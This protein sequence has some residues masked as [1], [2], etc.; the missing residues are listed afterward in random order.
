MS[1]K[2]A[3]VWSGV[4]S[5]LR[6]GLSFL[7]IKV[8]AFYLGPAGLALVGQLGNFITLL[9]GGLGN[10]IQTGVIKLTAEHEG[11]PEQQRAVWSSAFTLSTWLALGFGLLVCILAMP[12]SAWL[13][14]DTAYWP[15]FVLIG[16][17]TPFLLWNLVLTGA[18]NGIKQINALG[19]IS[20]AATVAGAV[21]FIPLSYVFGI[22]GGLAG[23]AIS[24]GAAFV[25]VL[26]AL[27]WIR[28]IR[29]RHFLAGH[30]PD[31]IKKLMSFYPMLI[32]HSVAV[33][34][35]TLLVR[36]MISSHLGLQQAGFWQAAWRLSDMYTQVLMLA[37]SMF[38]M[39]HLSGIKEE[40]VFGHELRSIVFKVTALTA[41]AALALYLLRD[42]LIL[43]VFTHEFK[44][45]S[46]LLLFQLLGDI[47]KM[48]GWPIR[49]ALVI[50][51][52]ARWYMFIEV[53]IALLQVTLTQFLLA[54]YGVKG[55]TMAYAASWLA[56]LI[57]LFIVTR[58]YWHVRRAT[59]D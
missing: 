30:Q 12:L 31:I 4:Q 34:L 5:V 23:T 52:R 47:F 53:A 33:P 54:G 17:L 43:I 44:P 18:V 51:L 40:R 19:A 20:V 49:M 6:L 56:A 21:I 15:A 36:D 57:V 55:A 3:L 16:G 50:K 58:E 48:A 38:L 26:A 27:F 41:L 25:V 9:S 46:D 32:V 37:L 14:E 42:W 10:A 35:A 28:E 2:K 13:L 7:S 8:T 24:S 1:L 39:P 11:N 22:P 59:Q 29:P 45:V